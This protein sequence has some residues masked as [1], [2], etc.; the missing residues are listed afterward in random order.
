MFVDTAKIYIKAGRGGNGLVSFHRE[1][2]VPAG[3]PDGGDGG[4]GGDVVFVA[5]ESFTTLMDFRYKKKYSAQNGEDG[6]AKN[7]FGKNGESIVIKVPTGT[8]IKDAKTEK[9]MADLSNHGE[10]FIAAHGGKGGWG[11]V[12]FATATRQAPRFAKNG[13][14]GEEREVILELKLLADVGLVGFPNVG[15]STILSRVSA[16]RPKIANYHFTTLEPNLGVVSILGT[17]FVIADIPGLIE[18][19]H[20]GLGLGHEFLRHIERTRIILHVVDVSGIEGRS[21]IDDY[22]KINYELEKYNEELKDTLQIVVA[23]KTDIV[24]DENALKEFKEYIEN[25]G[26]PLYFVSGATGEGLDALMKKT[27]ECLSTLGPKKVF[28]SD[29]LEPEKIDTDEFNITRENDAFVV[30]GPFVDKLL[31]GINFDDLES[32]NY[33]QRTLRKRGVIDKLRELGAKEGSLV[34]MD[35]LEF[36]F[37]E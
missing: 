12:H 17:S 13:I 23:N 6:K 7:S 9:I 15:K 35:E 26:F 3:G 22:E 16:A 1:K 2:Y 28:E 21:P 33:F 25:K 24:T 8:I 36:D 30:E 14:E 34:R 20:E 10:K 29:Y 32:L 5:D 18:G 31:R 19:A 37:V 27:A 11:N 4:R